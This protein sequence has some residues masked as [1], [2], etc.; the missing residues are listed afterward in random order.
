M[1]KNALILSGG[2][3]RAAYQVGVLLA[4]S[5][6]LPHLKNPFQIISGTSAGAINAVALAAHLGTFH[7]AAHELAHVWKQ[8]EFE[9]VINTGWLDLFKGTLRV[10]SSLFTDGYHDNV[11]LALLDNSPLR[12]LLLSIVDFE[13]IQQRIDEGQLHALCVT[14]LGYHSGE[15]V[16]FFQGHPSLRGWRRY[17]RVGAP[18]PITV[19]HIMASS[20]IPL[21]FPSVHVSK[22]YFGD[23][24]MRQTAPISCA[25]HTGAERL[26]IIGVS[27]N[28]AAGPWGQAG[29]CVSVEHKPSVAQI[30]GQVFNSA[31][32]DSIEGDIE[33][34]ERINNLVNLIPGKKM[35][36]TDNLRKID[37]LIISPST[38][39]DAIASRRIQSL[40]KSLKF[41]LGCSGASVKG[42]GV[43]A[44]SY[45]LFTHAFCDEL[46]DLGYTDALNKKDDI[47]R[48]FA[49]EAN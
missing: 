2:G 11:P 43:A 48:F 13:N 6:L 45:L 10:V 49:Q 12:N 47:E 32:I 16:S 1:A 35:R 26:L 19:D 21:I 41:F 34:L 7:R 44:A 22:E 33:R 30:L 5:E 42:G 14:A 24:A 9:H 20:A 3:A 37:S 27:E 38:R 18:M 40:P 28:L 4:V 39:I 8:I 15:S 36:E 23:G 31:F 17:R 46:I 29:K 25:L